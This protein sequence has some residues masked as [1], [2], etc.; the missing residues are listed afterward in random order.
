MQNVKKKWF[1]T[2]GEERA[3]NAF[4]KGLVLFGILV[5]AAET[6]AITVLALKPPLIVAVGEKGSEIMKVTKSPK[7]QI[8]NEIVR[9]VR[10][11]A[12]N[13]Y[14]WNYASIEA[15]FKAASKYV[16]PEFMKKFEEETS[17]QVQFAREKRLAQ[18]LYVADIKISQGKGEALVTGDRIIAIDNMHAASP[19]TL[20]IKYEIGRRSEEN[21]E[22]VYVTGEKVGPSGPEGGGK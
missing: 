13:R 4:L 12:A 1:E 19:L 21:P 7:E 20:S 22:G 5:V 9:I 3:Q 17:E 6:A 15:S 14:D 11:Y 10:S 2:W 16:A 8:E 18:K